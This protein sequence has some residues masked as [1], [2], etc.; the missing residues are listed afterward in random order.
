MRKLGPIV[1]A[2]M[3][4]LSCGT[5][6]AGSMAAITSME[7]Q[8][9]STANSQF[10]IK[11]TGQS[12]GAFKIDGTKLTILRDGFYVV[13]S[14]AQVSGTGT[15]DVYMWLRINGKDVPESNAIQ[16]I[17]LPKF[18]AVLVTQTGMDMKKND[19]LEIVIGATAPGLGIVA[20]KPANIPEVP[21]IILSVLEF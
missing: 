10:A 2:C 16:T 19:I 8:L 13:N 12:S 1:T 15:G 7:T 11:M 20:S 17:P 18:T 3:I 4:A 6:M 5:A 21:S 14:A 9:V